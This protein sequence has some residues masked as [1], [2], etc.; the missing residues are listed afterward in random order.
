M[1]GLASIDFMHK[2]TQSKY[3]GIRDKLKY[4]F[5]DSFTTKRT[6]GNYVYNHDELKSPNHINIFLSN[7]QSIKIRNKNCRKIKVED[8]IISVIGHES[9]H[10]AFQQTVP[11]LNKD[12]HYTQWVQYQ[13]GAM[14]LEGHRLYL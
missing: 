9:L 6:A 3:C 11:E 1:N 2:T 10:S 4:M 14:L 8:M 5:K 13:L 7:I 12:E